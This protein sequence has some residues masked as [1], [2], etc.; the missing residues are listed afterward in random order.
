M[1]RSEEK[2][3]VFTDLLNLVITQIKIYLN[4]PN[5]EMKNLIYLWPRIISNTVFDNTSSQEYCLQKV[6]HSE[7]K[8]LK[9]E[10]IRNNIVEFKSRIKELKKE[11]REKSF[12]KHKG[13]FNEEIPLL[14]GILIMN[15]NS[16]K[17]AIEEHSRIGQINFMS[18]HVVGR[19]QSSKYILDY[20]LQ[21]DLI[22]DVEKTKELLKKFCF[23]I[24]LEKI[25]DI[26]TK[27]NY[28]L[29]TIQRGNV[30]FEFY[31]EIIKG[32]GYQ[33]LS[34]EIRSKFDEAKIELKYFI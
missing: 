15:Q 29:E 3:I 32:L 5:S 28:K 23:T 4:H 19:E 34:A 22:M 13:A 26:H 25:S 10:S 16:L 20:I 9:R 1:T 6:Y 24:Q 33:G 27:A 8:Y 21:N 12:K 18:E 30:T 17:K 11:I 2:L 7:G 14:E 31:E